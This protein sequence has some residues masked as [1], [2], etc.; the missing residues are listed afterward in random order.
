LSSRLRSPTQLLRLPD[1][2]HLVT[3]DVNA[4]LA[5]ERAA[6]FLTDL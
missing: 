1:S 5:I 4:Q 2:N 6:A 3:L